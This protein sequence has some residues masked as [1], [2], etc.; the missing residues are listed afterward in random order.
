[1]YVV[2]GVN[3]SFGHKNVINHGI[4]GKKAFEGGEGGYIVLFY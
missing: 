3:F 1:M 4:A 2:P